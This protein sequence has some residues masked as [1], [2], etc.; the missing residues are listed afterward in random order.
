MID[1]AYNYLLSLLLNV[2]R[3]NLWLIKVIQA[4]ILWTT[5]LLV[6]MGR[7]LLSSNCVD[8]AYNSCSLLVINAASND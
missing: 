3:L 2:R 8:E 5:A 7:T 1:D 4:H 6:V